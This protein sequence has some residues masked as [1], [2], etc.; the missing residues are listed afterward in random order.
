MKH[1]YTK[2]NYSK[3]EKL[4]RKYSSYILCI[5]ENK[6]CISCSTENLLNEFAEELIES[7]F[8]EVEIITKEKKNEKGN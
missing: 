1:N 2:D 4:A 7:L 3:V 6:H 8:A 5:D